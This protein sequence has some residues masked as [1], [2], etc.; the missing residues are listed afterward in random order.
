[1]F[2]PKGNKPLNLIKLTNFI[3]KFSIFRPSLLLWTNMSWASILKLSIIYNLKL[4][5]RFELSLLFTKPLVSIRI[6]EPSHSVYSLP[7]WILAGSAPAK[8]DF[9]IVGIP[10][11]NDQTS[12]KILLT[13]KTRTTISSPQIIQAIIASKLQGLCQVEILKTGMDL[14]CHYSCV[15][16]RINQ[17]QHKLFLFFL[18]IIPLQVI[19]IIFFPSKTN[20][21]FL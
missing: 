14:V 15:N 5:L 8:I 19:L 1:M 18:Q 13:M 11:E 2:K 21:P 4:S 20:P 10:Q 16:Q 12:C 7:L 9:N 3:F 6:Q 17:I